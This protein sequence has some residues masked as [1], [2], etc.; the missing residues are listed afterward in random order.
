[1]SV[2]I[3]PAGGE[4]EWTTEVTVPQDDVK[5]LYIVLSVESGKARLFANYAVDV[6]D[7]Q[8]R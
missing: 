7:K 6:T 3:A 2:P 8:L 4:A 5:G 1:V